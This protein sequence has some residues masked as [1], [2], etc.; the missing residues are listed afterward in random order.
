MRPARRVFAPVRT[1]DPA[2]GGDGQANAAAPA[3][4]ARAGYVE[5]E[6]FFEGDALSYALESERT[7]DGMW[8]VVE[9]ASAPF[10]SRMIVRRPANPDAASGVVLVEWMNVTAAADAT[11]DWEFAEAEMTRE[12]HVW[13][14]VSAQQVGVRGG[15]AIL[16]GAAELAGAAAG[17]L[18][19]ADPE[20]YGT[21]V[22]PADAYAFDIFSQAA[23]ALRGAEGPAPLDGLEA[24][25]LIAIGESQSAAYLATYINAVHP[26]TGLFDG[27]LVHSRRASAALLD[28]SA[29]GPG[30][31]VRIRTDVNAPVL[32]FVTETDLTVLDFHAARQPDT[33]HLVTWEVAGTA[34]ADRFLMAKALGP[35]IEAS[36]LLGCPLPLNDG[37]HH[38]TVKAAL[39]H[40][41]EWT[42]ARTPPPTGDEIEVDSSVDGSVVLRRDELGNVLGGIRTPAVDVPISTLSGEP[43]P[44][45]NDLCSLF[46]STVA[47]DRATLDAL[48]PTVEE[49]VS[50]YAHSLGKAVEAGHILRP[51]ADALARASASGPFSD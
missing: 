19:A 23:A 38:Q 9:G 51:E 47:F 30:G 16:A 26:V 24:T 13:V 41:V 20:R 42:V 7:P 45:A 2:A 25:T 6:F 1:T 34:H 31:P 22:H 12:G 3:T 36:E 39:H 43:A 8:A 48:Y 40:L 21:L 33:E 37:P 32:Q 11:P 27:F 10:R 14:G 50:A 18:V 17:G 49:Y 29:Y 28:G 4:L 5:E 46:G 35:H 15:S 44:G